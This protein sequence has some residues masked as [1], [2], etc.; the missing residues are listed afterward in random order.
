[1]ASGKNIGDA[2]DKGNAGADHMNTAV[3]NSISKLQTES[4]DS[5]QCVKQ[6]QPDLRTQESHGK[7]QL[8]LLPPFLDS[9]KLSQKELANLED[10]QDKLLVLHYAELMSKK[11]SKQ[12][13]IDRDLSLWKTRLEA[14]HKDAKFGPD[15]RKLYAGSLSWLEKQA[16]PNMVSKLDEMGV[17]FEMPRAFLN[18]Q[19]RIEGLDPAVLPGR[20]GMQNINAAMKWLETAS[21]DASTGALIKKSDLP[22]NWLDRTGS[23]EEIENKRQVCQECIL[24][25]IEADRCV[26]LMDYFHRAGGSFPLDLPPQCTIE[27]D[28]DGNI[29]KVKLDLPETLNSV[30]RDDLSKQEQLK[31]WLKTYRP[32][33]DKTLQNLD[34]VRNFGTRALQNGE[35]AEKGEVK[36]N[37]GNCLYLS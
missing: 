22:V 29:F 4:L 31:Q 23:P 36:I 12:E 24:L 25:A 20:T 37:G 21:V 7:W 5:W 33:I 14:E 11:G 10:L 35:F 27:R 19:G 2:V 8:E 26:Q 13:D 17:G 6:L 1:M 9:D 30:N 18:Q 34:S 28:S 16:I 15:T 3:D 32:S